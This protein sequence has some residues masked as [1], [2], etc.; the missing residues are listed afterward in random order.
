MRSGHLPILEGSDIS[1]RR[2]PRLSAFGPT[3]GPTIWF[4]GGV[5]G[6]EV[7]GVVVIHELFK[8]LRKRPLARGIVHAFPLLNPMGFEA[9][10]RYVPLSGEDMGRSFPGSPAGS[11]AERIADRVFQVILE[12]EPNL[13]LD[14]H[15]DWR[16]SIPYAVLDAFVGK[17]HRAAYAEA[18]RAGQR[19]GFLP[20]RERGDEAARFHGALSWAL[21]RHDV[22]ALTIELGESDVVN[23]LN[24][25]RGLGC[26]WRLLGEYGLVEKEPEPYRY[27]L[28]PEFSGR[29]LHYSEEPLSPATGIL[30]F[31][32][33]PGEVVRR[34]KPI[35]RIVDS[36]GRIKHTLRAQHDGIVLGHADAAVTHPGLPVMAF[37]TRDR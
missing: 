11:P 6:D 5:H 1:E 22:P 21:L 36:L 18:R 24:V 33:G 4:T 28:P 17:R 8:R 35:A 29:V 19:S 37:A 25:Q 10:T 2:I 14:L 7:T 27:E 12:T 32:R 13:V 26:L 16:H 31:L 15:N 30:R 3:P 34:E 9:H 20:L 23:E